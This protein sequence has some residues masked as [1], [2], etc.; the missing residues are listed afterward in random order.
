MLRRRFGKS[1]LYSLVEVEIGCIR[2]RNEGW[3]R[4]WN[5]YK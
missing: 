1:D 5:K 3:V 2:L 4:K